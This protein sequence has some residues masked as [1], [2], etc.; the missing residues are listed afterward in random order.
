MYKAETK[1]E[2]EQILVSLIRFMRE[3][4][5]PELY[6]WANTLKRHEPY[7][8]NYFDNHTTNAVTEGLHR[9]FK[10][11]QR[12]AFGFRNPEVYIRRVMLAFLP[13][14]LLRLYPHY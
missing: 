13:L 12:Q 11:I 3:S 7:I 2:A 8:L 4:E 6:L 5:Y 1:Q 9:K 10:L 14:T